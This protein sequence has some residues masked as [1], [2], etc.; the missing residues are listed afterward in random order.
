MKDEKNYSLLSHNTFGIDARCARYV[1]ASTVCEVVSFVKLFDMFSNDLFVIGG[2]SN[3][4]FTG[5]YAGTV[6]HSAILGMSVVGEDTD[7]V[8]LRVG[9]GEVWDDVVAYCVANGMYGAENL[10]A[11]PGE[12][13][14]SAVQ[15]IGAYGAEVKDIIYKVEA[16]EIATGST[17]E[18]M[19]DDCDYSYRHSRFKTDWKNRYIITHVT[20]RLSKQ[21]NP[22][23]DYGNIRSELV[24]RGIVNPTAYQ[25][26]QVIV[27]IRNAKLPNPKVEGNAGS[28]FMNPIVERDCYEKLVVQYPDMPHYDVDADRVKIPAG[29]M[30]D[31]CGWKGKTVGH[32][33]VH[34]RQALVLVNRG[35]AEGK[36]II[37][38]CNLVRADVKRTFG[39]DIHPEV[40]F[41][42]EAVKNS[43]NHKRAKLTFLGTGTSC[44]VPT[45]GCQCEVCTSSDSR[46][47][48]LRSSAMIETDDTRVIIDCTPDFRQQMMHRE[49]RKIDGVLVTHSHYDHVGGTDDVRPFCV[50][51]DINIYANEKAV[52]GMHQMLPYCF[53]EHLYPGVPKL[54]L[55]TIAPHQEIM[56][57]DIPVFPITVMHAKLPILGYRF[58]NRLAYI[59]DMKS[60]SPEEEQYVKCVDTLVVNA[61]R[62]EEEH[63]SHILLDEAVEFAKRIG[64]RHTYFIHMSHHIGLHE[65]TCTMLPEGMSLAY[66]G[67]EVEWD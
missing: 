35:G 6:F 34:S 14:A 56:I 41:I 42:G 21:Y 62:L 23:L 52:E 24:A 39:I 37:N 36:D 7:N 43:F 10:S 26:R 33:G 11:I 63:Q 48:R 2:G 8:L 32:A 38:L 4:L 28:F 54:N 44:G 29:W 40:N 27:D 60:I 9:S 46:D 5:D 15:N 17:V 61:L 31:R 58:G 3:L 13:G 51:G 53:A 20:Y 19:A 16:V 25:L 66:D 65:H 45:I 59:T 49:F 64:A 18:I 12:A 67:L 47:S 30:I 22:R 50:F 55:H 1:E 57:G